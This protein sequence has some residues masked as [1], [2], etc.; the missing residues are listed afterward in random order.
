MTRVRVPVTP[1]IRDKHVSFV[2]FLKH[3]KVSRIIDTWA[4]EWNLIYFDLWV[5][6]FVERQEKTRTRLCFFT[7]KENIAISENWSKFVTYF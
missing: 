5:L 7:R 6:T 3:V 2:P 1:Q 4:R